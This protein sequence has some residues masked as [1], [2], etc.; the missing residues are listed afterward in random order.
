LPLPFQ[1]AIE[2]AER[3]YPY[4]EAQLRLQWSEALRHAG[5]IAE[6]D[7]AWS[8]AVRVAHAGWLAEPPLQ[9]PDYWQRVAY[10]RPVDQAWPPELVKTLPG[11]AARYGAASS[12]VNPHDDGGQSAL[13]DER[14]LWACVGH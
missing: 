5:Q 12:E 6:A 1:R 10:H 14:H 11:L 7:V 4:Y 13:S 3:E 2:S 8:D 9:D